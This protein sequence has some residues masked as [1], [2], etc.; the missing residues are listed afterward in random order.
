MNSTKPL[1]VAVI[2]AGLGG[3]AAAVRLAVHGYEVDVYEQSEG[4]GGKAGV[5][6]SDGF[7]FDTGPSLLTLPDVFQDLFT[8]SDENIQD[9]LEYDKLPLL[10][11]Y[12]YPDGTLLNCYSDQEK[13]QHEIQT[14]FGAEAGD[15]REYFDYTAT[16]YEAAADYFLRNPVETYANPFHKANWPLY[17]NLLK[18][19]AFRSMH[20]ANVA[21]FNDPRLVQLFDR[22]ATYNGSSPF[23]AP[24]TLNMISHVEHTLG[25]F[26]V[27]GGIHEITKALYQLALKKGVHFYFKSKVER[28]THTN[29]VVRGIKI[30]EADIPYDSVL[31][32]IDVYKTFTEL[33]EDTESKEIKRYLKQEPSSSVIV[34][35]WGMSELFPELD[36][37]NIFFSE[38]YKNEFRQIF[39][40]GLVPD[41]PTIYINITSK[42]DSV[43][44]PPGCE[45]WFV[46]VNTPY[47][48]GQDWKELAEV[49]RERIIDKLEK[50]LHR[51][52]GP[53]IKVEKCFTPVDIAAST[54][55]YLGS[56]YGISSNSR[57]AAFR[58]QPNR[59]RSYKNLYFCGG[60]AHPGGGMPLVVLS[61]KIASELIVEDH[62]KERYA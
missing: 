21:H 2:G 17:R 46:L 37:H 19:D 52:I 49:L 29:G 56:L 38:H 44:A 45:N 13:L 48:S 25:G 34:F 7:R 59:S 50:M 6:E 10:C 42:N 60:S 9:Y 33:L 14:K 23:K 5:F 24:A 16:M 39:N 32:N 55:S 36:T 3:L 47:D 27:K 4:A 57:F 20:D 40:D 26:R 53:M 35:L 30:H 41:D 11:R 62:G 1:K 54:G 28:I 15:I 61:G 22:Y 12:F 51:D 58:R 18:I 31:S 43:D 8:F